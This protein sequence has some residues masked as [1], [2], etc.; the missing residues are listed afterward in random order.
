MRRHD[1]KEACVIPIILRPCDWT[2]SPFGKLQALPKDARP[3]TR[4]EDRDEAFLDV[5][6]GIRKA[7]EK[8]TKEAETRP[9]VPLLTREQVSVNV[10][11]PSQ[12]I[13][14]GQAILPSPKQ[15]RQLRIFLCH[16]SGDKQA[17]RQLYL[18]LRQE[19]FDP[20]LDEEKLLPGQRWQDEIQKAVRGSDVVLV[21][22]SKSS[23]GKRGYV[24]KEIKYALDVADEQPE[25][26]I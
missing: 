1:A 13:K 26:T 20:W 22:L 18:R 19:G 6:T 15:N 24:Q 8:K 5:A 10:P 25:G 4:W 21:C 14:P 11:H 17:V 12:Q 2:N 16:S 23:L 7:V 9:S 3:I